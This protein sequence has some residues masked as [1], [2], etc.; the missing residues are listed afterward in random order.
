MRGILF[1]FLVTR[2]TLQGQ[3]LIQLQLEVNRNILTVAEPV[4]GCLE[5]Y[6]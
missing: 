4:M 3:L 6:C 2:L 5:S 1:S